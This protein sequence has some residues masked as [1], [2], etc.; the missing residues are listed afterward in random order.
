MKRYAFIFARGGSKGL[1]KKN[2]MH[3]NG[4]PL[5]H[6]A[7]ECAQ[8]VKSIE[9]IFVSTDCKEIS[10]VADVKDIEI[11]E[12]PSHLA[13]DNAS[14]WK[15]W[16]HAIEWVEQKYGCFDEFVSL[17]TTSPLRSKC[18]VENA[19]KVRQEINADI[20]VSMTTANRNPY[21]NMVKYKDNGMV[22]LVCSDSITSRRQD[23]PQVFDL[24]TVVY[25]ASPEFIKNN[26]S[27]FSGKVAS[28]EVP[29][30]RA[31][32]IDDMFDFKF[33]EFLIKEFPNVEE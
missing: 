27:M 22:E 7:I 33:A 1:P 3:L 9:R 13:T 4:K 30:Y 29:K 11:I 23:A 31:V 28:I 20:C 15:A 18:D 2:I 32:D 6:Y 5:I 10:A 16:Q 21:F 26:T 14:E 25:C 19:I 8:S 12:R 17:P 24:T